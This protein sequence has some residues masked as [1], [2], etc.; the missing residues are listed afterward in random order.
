CAGGLPTMHAHDVGQRPHHLPVI[1]DDQN[2]ASH[3]ASAFAIG[4]STDTVDPFPGS[5]AADISAPLASARL[6]DTAR[7]SP[8]PR[9]F[10]V[11][12]GSNILS[13]CWRVM[14]TPVSVTS[15][16]T[17]PL[18]LWRAR[19]VRVPPLPSIACSALVRRLSTT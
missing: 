19:R 1:V 9:A 15:S 12:R 11:N 3:G 14:P 7:P 8:M 6:F 2:S 18:P 10:V 4:M 5:L 13:S 17:L 16:F